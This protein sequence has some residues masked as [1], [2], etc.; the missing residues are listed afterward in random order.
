M[1]S[2][3]K[4]YNPQAV[5]ERLYEQWE[6]R[7]YFKPK[8]DWSKKPFVI[9]MPPPNV[10]GELH[11]GHAIT[12]SIQ[13][14]MI[15]YHR[16]RGEPILWLPGEDHASIAAQYVVEKEIAQ[17]GLTK[18]GLGREGF[19]ERVWQWMHKYRPI[20]ANQH[21]RLG[22]S[23]DWT[24][25]KFTMDPDLCRAVREAFVR[26]F[27][28][29]LIYRGEYLINWCP[30]CKTTLADL[31]VEHEEE[32]SK[33]WYVRYPLV[34]SK[35]QEAGKWGSGN[36]AAGAEEFITVATTRPETILGDSAV[37]V[38]PNDERYRR[39]VGRIAI[40]PALGRRIPVIA[41]EAVDRE[42]GTGAVK[43]T[44]AHDPDD[45]QIGKHHGL[46]QINVMNEDATMNEEAGPYAG[47]DRFECRERM[48]EDL[49]KEGL[50]VKVEPHLHS[51][52]RCYRCKTL[53]EPRI[54]EQWFV[55]TKPLAEPAI[56]A[57]R[58]RRIRIIPK[59]FEKVYFNWMENIRDWCI[60]RQ[61]WWGHRIPVWYCDDCGQMSVT[62]EETLEACQHCGSRNI[63]Q[64]EDVLDTWFSSALWPFSTLGWP[65]DTEDLRYFYPTTVMET[66]YDILFFW[67]ARMIMMGLEMTGREPF[68]VVYL[69]G[70][71]RDEHGR[72]MSKSLGNVIDPLVVMDEYGTDAL[73]FT[74]LTGSTPGNDMKLSLERVE[75]NRNFANK[76]WNAARFVLAQM[77]NN[78]IPNPNR[79]LDIGHCS[80][81][82]RWI[83]SRHN[84]LVKEVTRLI[85][86]YQ[87]GEA[88]RLI[89]GFLWGEFCDWYIEISKI[90]LYGEDEEARDIAR[91]VLFYVLERT[92][93]LLH[94]FM[95]FVTE[96][97]WQHLRSS[98]QMG[99]EL[100]ESIMIAPWPEVDE[101]LLDEEAEKE[102]GLVMEAVR[103]IRNAR[104]EYKVEPGR[105]IEALIAAGEK[106][107]LLEGQQDV[108]ISL[109]R[110]DAEKLRL[111]RTLPE[112]PARALTLVVG[113]GEIYLPLAGMVDLEAERKRL[114]SEIEELE[115]KIARSEELLAKE[116]FLVK[117][118]AEV[119]E[120]EKEKLAGYRQK[121]GKLKKRLRNR[122]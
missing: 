115:E 65:D 52:G 50:L 104:A 89:H 63:H 4:T 44:P 60:S 62:A 46:A 43:I 120:R 45:Y 41:D 70:L 121:W 58:E 16:M 29:G 55:R 22:A 110:L 61:L 13:D 19:L 21:R 27:K 101:A 5:E 90:R 105:R 91:W 108:L 34:S 71:I 49:E 7:G 31:E 20:I 107:D 54:S 102:M 88:G 111:A 77:T 117:A 14:L 118:P 122:G 80:L 87:F 30:R 98:K 15:R 51:P 99:G 24:R 17:E 73:R 39:L 8:L 79:S 28:K 2:M 74:L 48:V 68:R 116:D 56:R 114:R 26:L 6:K 97:I 83:L 35:W 47:L 57:V 37:A 94:P 12:A 1:T 81:P 40:L 86:D 64:D 92:M 69:H 82:E 36:W 76:I 9:S 11:L 103:A 23:C 113:D 67:V 109:A 106:F 93:R 38:H 53:V 25:E 32:E 66:G 85:E 59:R 112:R 100:S 72:K 3:P 75:G 42:F 96:E 10:T 84:R 33:L 18:E 95:P 78:Q 119:V